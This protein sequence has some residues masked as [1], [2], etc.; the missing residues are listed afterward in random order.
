V[1]VS[2]E[3]RG[4]TD[5]DARL[6]ALGHRRTIAY[7]TPSF[8]S[9][10]ALVRQ[11]D[12]VLNVPARCVNEHDGVWTEALPFDVPPV[13]VYLLRHERS[14]ADAGLGWLVARLVAVAED[15]AR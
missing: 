1:L 11:C 13:D 10:L 14:V 9:A 12:L 8:A 7:R 6:A 3:G 15:L 5:V 4:P 2:P